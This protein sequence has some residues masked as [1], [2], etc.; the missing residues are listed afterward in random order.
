MSLVRLSVQDVEMVFSSD[1]H[2]WTPVQSGFVLR[3]LGVDGQHE[4]SSPPPLSTFTSHIIRF[5]C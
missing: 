1:D 2:F 3:F 5:A 4:A